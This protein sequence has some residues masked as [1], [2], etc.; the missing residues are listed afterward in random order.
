MG[1]RAA[2]F[3]ILVL[4]AARE[5]TLSILNVYIIASKED[6]NWLQSVA[7]NFVSI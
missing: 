3:R 4:I 1:Y 7:V 6:D 5:K 2:C